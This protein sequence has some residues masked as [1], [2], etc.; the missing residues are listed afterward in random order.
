MFKMAVLTCPLPTVELQKIQEQEELHWDSL[1]AQEDKVGASPARRC[2][3]VRD[4]WPFFVQT[5]GLD[6]GCSGPMA[7]TSS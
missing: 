1:F 5:M 4:Q 6:V 7:S 2:R 3:A